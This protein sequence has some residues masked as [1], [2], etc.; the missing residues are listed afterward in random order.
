MNEENATKKD[1]IAIVD[2]IRTPF[3]KAW[4]A[5][6]GVDADDLGAYVFREVLAR[7]EFLGDD[8]DEV[9]LGNCSQPVKA[10]NIAKVAALKACIAPKIPAF[11]VQRNC[12][13]GMQAVASGMDKILAGQADVILA[14]GAESMTNIPLIYGSKMTGLFQ[15]LM[16]SKTVM[17]KLS[18]LLS[19]RL[20]F[21]KPI[22]GLEAG[23][24]DYFENLIMG[25]T[26]EILARDFHITR[27]KQ[28]AFA[29]KSHQKATVAIS[30][31]RLAEEILPIPLAP[32][33]QGVQMVDDGPRSN[34]TTEALAKLR[35]YFD[36]V[37]GTVTAGSSSQVTDGAAAVLL[38]RESKAKEMGYTPLGYVRD[39][40]FAS[41]EGKRMGLGPVYATD[42]LLRRTG[43]EMSDFKLVELNEAFA[44]QVIAC[45]MAFSSDDYCKK[46]LGRDKA[47]G[48]LND[49]ILNVNGGGIALGHPVGATGTRIIITLLKELR[50]RKE[51]L[52]LATLCVGGGQGAAFAL[53]VE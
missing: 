33:F 53:E 1:R 41:L 13:S 17:Q 16:R 25:K 14:G 21:L 47:M 24:T 34:Q 4:G 22:V 5:F 11:S 7:T 50:R 38:M 10:A 48:E 23:L 46:H 19:F 43:L 42:K 40:A 49:D 45:Q 30:S 39:Y 37:N 6:K 44:A 3:C 8:L 32:K 28:D 36:R 52:G 35:P 2:G 12:A 31:G 26:A 27:E 20:G 18:T 9:V 29:L 15:R 51:N